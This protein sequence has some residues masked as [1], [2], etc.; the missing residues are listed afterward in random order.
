MTVNQRRL[1]EEEARR[2]NEKSILLKNREHEVEQELISAEREAQEAI[3]KA[4]QMR[5]RIRA[6]EGK[7][8]GN[9]RTNGTRATP[10]AQRRTPTAKK[11]REERRMEKK[12]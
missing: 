3:L 1:A 9:G 7:K 6:E 5:L 4:K 8:K 2:L 12:S 11:G 10:E